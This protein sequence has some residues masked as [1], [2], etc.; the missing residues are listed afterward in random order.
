MGLLTR[1][2]TVALNGAD[3]DTF[4]RKLAHGLELVDRAAASNPDIVCLPETFAT[5]HLSG[6]PR[7]WAQPI[8]GDLVSA[9]A[10]RAHRHEC[11]VV[12]PMLLGEDDRVYNASVLIDRTGAIA[13]VYRKVHLVASEPDYSL[14]E[15]GLTPGAEYPVFASDVGPVGVQICFDLEFDEGWNAL[16]R[17]GARIVFWPSAYDGG[18]PLSWYAY[19]NS[20]YVVGSVL[21]AHARV[22]DPLGREIAAT[23]SWNQVAVSEISTDFVVCHIDY[24]RDLWYEI[25]EKYGDRVRCDVLGEESRLL[26]QSLDDDLPASEIVR[27]FGLDPVRDYIDR[28]GPALQEM[29]ERG[30]VTP[31]QTPFAARPK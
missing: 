21:T 30:S 15:S 9:V 8:D 1:I 18:M 29:R 2:A 25:V 19:H 6:S 13:G 12:C 24:H 28:H 11:A 5:F 31:R 16:G 27:E 4:D 26:V 23:N 17:S 10:D 3:F 20:Y 14:L 22:V 7:R